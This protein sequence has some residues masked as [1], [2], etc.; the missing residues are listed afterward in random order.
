MGC[1]LNTVHVVLV[2]VSTLSSR[3]RGRT[4]YERTELLESHGANKHAWFCCCFF[5]LH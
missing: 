1:K 5:V 3:A 4:M 2:F